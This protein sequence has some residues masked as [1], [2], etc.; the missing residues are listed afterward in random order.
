MDRIFLATVAGFT[1]LLA[2]I[3]IF[4]VYGFVA[5]VMK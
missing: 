4:R 3:G 2:V 5:C 1:K